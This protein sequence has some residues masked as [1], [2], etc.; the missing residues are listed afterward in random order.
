MVFSKRMKISSP[1][2][3]YTNSWNKLSII[4]EKARSTDAAEVPLSKAPKVSMFSCLAQA[5][6]HSSL[7]V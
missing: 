4:S 1:S 2:S 7:V 6:I 3:I 5:A